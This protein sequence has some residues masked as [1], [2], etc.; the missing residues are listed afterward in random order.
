[1]RVEH[2]GGLLDD[3]VATLRRS[4]ERAVAC[5]VPRASVLVDP[6]HDFG[7][8]TW[9]SLQLLRRTGTLAGLGSPLLVALSRKALVG[10]TS[11]LP[12][13]ERLEG[14]LAATAVA[15]WLG[16]RVFRADDGR[17]TR[18]VLDLVAAVRDGAPP[19]A[20]VRGLA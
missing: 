18:R 7:T 15:A 2:P 8:N 5:G 12:P 14:A 20:A 16:A 1:Y 6:T 11:D 19:A 17:A 4:A 13:D 3:V 9:Q 10:A